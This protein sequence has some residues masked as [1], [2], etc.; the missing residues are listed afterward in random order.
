M[1]KETVLKELDISLSE[2]KK[3]KEYISKLNDNKDRVKYLRIIKRYTQIESAEIIGI[4]VRQVQRIEKK[5]KKSK[6]VV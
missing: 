4:S 5:F 3:D 1:I 6:N 2:K